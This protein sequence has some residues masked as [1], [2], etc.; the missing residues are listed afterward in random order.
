[1]KL[2]SAARSS[3]ASGFSPRSSRA[4]GPDGELAMAATAA[5]Q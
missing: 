3:V 5:L 4:R 2:G 1:M